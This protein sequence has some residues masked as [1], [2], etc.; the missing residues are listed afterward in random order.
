M[1]TDARTPEMDQA[2]FAALVE[3][4]GA[5]PKRWPEK[6]R[7]AALVFAETPDGAESLRRA[8][9][10]DAALDLAHPPM[11]A[12]ALAGRILAGAEQ[13]VTFAIRLRRFLVGA[14]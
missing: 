10:L 1:R 11:P 12:A 3:T 13:R 14:G 2:A 8:A 5:D 7:A 6:R 4:Y 9:R